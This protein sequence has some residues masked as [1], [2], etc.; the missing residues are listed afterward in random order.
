[1]SIKDS[2]VAQNQIKRLN[3]RFYLYLSKCQQDS[4]C[5]KAFSVVTSTDEDILS[6]TLRLQ[7]LFLTNKTD[8]TCTN[9]LGLNSWSLFIQIGNTGIED[10]AVRPLTVILIARIYRCSSEDQRVLSRAIPLM[11]SFIEKLLPGGLID[12]PTDYPNDGGVLGITTI[13]SDFLGLTLSDSVKTNPVFFNDF[14]VNSSVSNELYL[15]PT[16]IL[17]ICNET[18]I[19]KYNYTA[20]SAFKDVLYSKNPR[21]WGQFQV[22]PT[23]FHSRKGGALLFNGD[24]DYNSPLTTAQQVRQ[25]FELQDIPTKLISMKG[26]THVT[27]IQSYTKQGGFQSPSCTEEIIVQFL[28][29]QELNLTLSDLNDQCDSKENLIGIDWFYKNPTINQTLHLLF[30]NSTYNYWGI[31]PTTNLS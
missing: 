7:M 23:I 9:N 14:C 15:A 19:S 4:Q 18:K 3:D 2:D 17:P 13:W 12:P 1:M 22:S 24:L 6:V 26:L 11:I 28:Y 31:D 20:S 21:Y 10:V 29:Q 30:A 27:G 5:S 8:P 16:G 25:F